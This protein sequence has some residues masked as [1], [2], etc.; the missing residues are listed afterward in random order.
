M[1]ITRYFAILKR[2]IRLINVVIKMR[3]KNSSPNV[4]IRVSVTY[5]RKWMAK[6]ARER[7]RERGW[8][9]I[10]KFLDTDC[11]RSGSRCVLDDAM[12]SNSY[13]IVKRQVGLIGWLDRGSD[14]WRA[15]I[16]RD[17]R[18]MRNWETRDQV[19]RSRVSLTFTR[20]CKI[21]IIG[22]F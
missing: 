16:L 11:Q 2:I 8:L 6:K 4:L 15:A 21:Q 9:A 18:C 3:H 5:R 19:A 7:G 13:A 1:R 17:W 22:L 10:K 14:R 20:F 12:L